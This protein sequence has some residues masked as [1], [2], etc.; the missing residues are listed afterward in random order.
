M[1]SE[2]A[3]QSPHVGDF[4]DTWEPSNK[5][6]FLLQSWLNTL[7]MLNNSKL[8]T[9]IKEV[10]SFLRL[11]SWLLYIQFPFKMITFV[12]DDPPRSSR[13]GHELGSTSSRKE[14]V[15]GPAAAGGVVTPET[16]GFGKP[17]DVTYGPQN[18]TL[19]IEPNSLVFWKHLILFRH[20]K[21]MTS[22]CGLLN[23]ASC[24]WISSLYPY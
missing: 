2:I 21:K 19:E 15:F 17:N 12:F 4:P 13:Q 3:K 1:Q 20:R 22:T 14:P 23:K 10:E 6:L 7:N 24:C 5:G 8:S 18:I 9:S 11:K 16:R